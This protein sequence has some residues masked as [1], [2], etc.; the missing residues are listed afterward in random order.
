MAMTHAQR[1]RY[2]STM[3]L[4]PVLQVS[5]GIILAHATRSFY[6]NAV[7]HKESILHRPS[8][9]DEGLSSLKKTAAGRCDAL[10]YVMYAK[11]R[12]S[13]RPMTLTANGKSVDAGKA[14]TPSPDDV[15]HL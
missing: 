6:T 15:I 10:G 3:P 11:P 5:A 1:L 4:S 8:Q 12:L 7:P 14:H 9:D 13:K 2:L